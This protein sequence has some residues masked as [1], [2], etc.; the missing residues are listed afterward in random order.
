MSPPQPHLAA[1]QLLVSRSRRLA[2]DA[3]EGSVISDLLDGRTDEEIAQRRG[4]TPA[5]VRGVRSFYDHLDAI[6]RVC[7]GTACHFEGAGRLRERLATR[8]PCGDVRC[9]GRCYAA[10]AFESGGN[11]FARPDGASLDAWLGG[12]DDAL[13]PER[14]PIP[15]KS[16]APNPVVLK[17]LLGDGGDPAA[18]YELP[19]GAAILAA[20][21]RAR[22]HGRGGA[23]FPTW[24][25]WRAARDAAGSRKFVVANG[26]EGDPGSFVDRLL[27]EERPHA[28]LAGMQACARATGARDGFVYVRAEYPQAQRAMR[29]AI[30]EARARGWLDATFEVRVVS[31][32]G[33]Y[34]CGEETA[35]LQSIEGLRGEPR[36][37]PP[38]PAERGLFDCPTV[39]QNVE[40]LALVP[41][42]IRH[43]MPTGTKV[44]C[45][46][47]ALAWRGAVEIPLGMPLRRVLYEVG[48][49][50]GG[51]DWSMA[52]IGGPMGRVLP[53]S[54]FDTPLSW[55]ALP[56][57][58]HAGIVVLD[59]TVTPRALAEHLFAFAR[60]ESCGQCTPCRAGSAQLAAMSTRTGL[61]RLLAT[62]EAGSRCGF[63]QGVS[64]PIRDLLAHFGDRV[65]A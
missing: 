58:G 24:I 43:A 59:H 33:S 46:S 15:R 16:L 22:I 26:D 42:A 56:G 32:A 57:M 54:R 52:L 63:G 39:V 34:V 45:L 55:E 53:E 29:E 11:A 65:L 60:A 13:L 64:R 21:E 48:G 27:L 49:G 18:E 19:D 44:A 1:D 4:L 47:G 35:L 3:P 40:T 31:G 8:G 28:V 30:A 20:V 9:L 62:M 10:P 25:K 12:P 2:P 7:D 61:E 14:G 23:G 6:P 17:T 37:K 38:Y 36:I 51:R 41:W 50:P 5:A